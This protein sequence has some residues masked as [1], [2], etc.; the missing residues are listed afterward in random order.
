MRAI[1]AS[2]PTFAHAVACQRVRVAEPP[3]INTTKNGRRA[4]SRAIANRDAR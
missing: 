3:T 2:Y 4:L 1:Q